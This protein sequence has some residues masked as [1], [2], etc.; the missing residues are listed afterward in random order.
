MRGKT[1]FL[2]LFLTLLLMAGLTVDFHTM[3]LGFGTAVYAFDDEEDEYEDD[4]D[5]DD[6]DGYLEGWDF[7]DFVNYIESGEAEETGLKEM[8]GLFMKIL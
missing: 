2:R 7:N 6:D 8:Y 5:D 1:M 4:D 3:S